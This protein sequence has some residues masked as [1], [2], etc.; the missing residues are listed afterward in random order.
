M[1]IGSA[2]YYED[3]IGAGHSEGI[4]V[5]SSSEHQF[6][7]W[8]EIAS[9]SST[10]DG[11]GMDDR[12]TE[13]ARFLEQATLGVDEDIIAQVAMMDFGDWIDAQRDIPT[14]SI[15]ELMIDII[16]E[17]IDIYVA[18]GGNAEDYF[19]PGYW[20]FNYAWWQK[21]MTNEDLLRQRVTY[22]LSQILVISARGNLE[23]H[24][25]GMAHYYDALQ[26]HAF[27]N[28]RDLLQ[29]VTLHPA[30]GIYLT[31]F[32]NPK[33]IEDLN[34]RPDEN[35]AREIMQLFS[36]GLYE[37]NMDGS[38]VMDGGEPVPTYGIPEI[39]EFAKVFTGLGAGG[40]TDNPFEDE[41]YFGISRY[42]TDFTVPM[43]MYEE[44]HEPGVKNLLYGESTTPGNSGMEDIEE[45]ID[46]IFN[47]PNV[48]PFIARRLI[49]HLVKSN[50]SPGYIER[51]AQVF[52]DNGEGVR[53]DLFA[54]VK[55]ILLDE[56][57]RTCEWLTDPEHGKLREPMLRYSSFARMIDKFADE[58]RFWNTGYDFQAATDQAPLGAYSVFNF[59]LPDFQPSGPLGEADL[60]GPEYQ[61]HN[62]RTSLDF[63]NQALLWTNYWPL[64]YSWEEI[65]PTFIILGELSEKARD[66]DVLIDYLD[67]CYVRGQMSEEL[68]AN[69]RTTING[70]TGINTGPNF[71]EYRARTALYLTLIS[72][73][74]SVL[75]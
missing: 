65:D 9:G 45:A 56:E 11:S 59:F 25:G 55:A 63:I 16:Y 51:I 6:F 46:N 64:F 7:G 72:P 67:K 68:R 54:T 44:W 74:Y 62:S 26:E 32:N 60:Y 13:T 22:A 58:G 27:G 5:T 50:P 19:A 18:N 31:H 48:P 61:I 75:R 52:A 30:M 21:N 53:G 3:Y 34:I 38:L 29:K 41:P 4:T 1:L 73:D 8:E 33:T 14:E 2:Q 35:Y 17:A 20:H 15:R 71:L 42:V 66:A 57:A 12:F 49:Q 23:E 69:L 37:L 47:H 70:M 40:V 39:K 24:V 28:Y 43:A 10:I 36:I